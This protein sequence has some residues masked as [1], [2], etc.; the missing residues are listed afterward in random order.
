MITHTQNQGSPL[1]ELLVQQIMVLLQPQTRMR[2]P[3]FGQ[4][5]LLVRLKRRFEPPFRMRVDRNSRFRADG[6]FVRLAGR[7]FQRI[8]SII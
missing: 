7:Q 1:L 8:E 4:L 5:F 3:D 6:G 2:L